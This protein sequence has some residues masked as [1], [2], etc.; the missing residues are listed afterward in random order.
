MPAASAAAVPAVTVRV[1]GL[2]RT[3]LAPTLILARSGSVTRYGA[4]RGV[5]PQRSAQGALDVATKH[6]WG[7]KWEASFGSYEI[8]SILGETHT[9]SS[10]Y[11]WELFANNVGASV[12][13]CGLQLRP[14]QQLLFAAVP[15][16]VGTNAYPTAMRAPQNAVVGIPFKVKVVWFNAKG[17]AE[18]LA[19]AHVTGSGVSASTNGHGVA[20]VIALRSGSLVLDAEHAWSATTAFVRATPV[21]VHVA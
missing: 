7:G 5:C 2:K 13:A 15:Q 4:P 19:G 11:Y 14:G 6:R 16:T 17:H 9:F 20:T 12:G 8:L 3:L 18:P 21:T 1:E 10:K